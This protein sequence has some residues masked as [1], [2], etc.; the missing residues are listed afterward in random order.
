MSVRDSSVKT[1][2]R[3]ED[4]RSTIRR[5]LD[6]GSRRSWEVAPGAYNL[7]IKFQDE[8]FLEGDQPYEV[9]TGKETTYRVE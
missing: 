9:V 3:L 2:R 4:D 1:L 6:P 5:R 7:R 8:T